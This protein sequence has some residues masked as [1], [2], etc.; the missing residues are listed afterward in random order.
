MVTYVARKSLLGDSGFIEKLSV[1]QKHLAIKDKERLFLCT[2]GG[3]PQSPATRIPEDKDDKEAGSP[4]RQSQRK[5]WVLGPKHR[6]SSYV[7]NQ[8][9]GWTAKADCVSYGLC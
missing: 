6:A 8:E 4:E 1:N 7:F 3:S 5:G 2:A 9:R